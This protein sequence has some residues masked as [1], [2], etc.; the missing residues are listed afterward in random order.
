[1]SIITGLVKKGDITILYLLNRRIHCNWL[2]VFMRAVTQLG[3]TGFSVLLPL[4]LMLTAQQGIKTM[5]AE[6]GSTLIL[7]QIIVQ[8]L[9]RLVNRPRPYNILKDIVAK[10]PPACKY[11]FPSGHTCAAFSIAFQIAAN[12]PS[13]AVV[14]ILIASMVAVSRIYLGFHYPSDVAVGVIIA[15]ISYLI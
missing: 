7:G 11:S 14:L 6:I 2:N 9:K 8:L 13:L 10:K 12:I 15:Y 1:L 3:S 4:I 5:G